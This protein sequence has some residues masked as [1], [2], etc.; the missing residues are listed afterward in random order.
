MVGDL[1]DIVQLGVSSGLCQSLIVGIIRICGTNV[2]VG[3][4]HASA[5]VRVVIVR[6]LVVGGTGGQYTGFNNVIRRGQLGSVD[7]CGVFLAVNGHGN[8]F[9]VKRSL[10]VHDCKGKSFKFGFARVKL[11]YYVKIA[12]Q[13]VFVLKS[14]CVVGKL[15]IGACC[16]GAESRCGFALNI[17][18]I[19][20]NTNSFC[21]I[22][23]VVKHVDHATAGR[24]RGCIAVIHGQAF[25][26]QGKLWIVVGALHDERVVEFQRCTIGVRNN[27]GNANRHAV[28]LLQG[29]HGCQGV[30]KNKLVVARGRFQQKFAVGGVVGGPASAVWHGAV[31][32]LEGGGG[33]QCAVVIRHMEFANNGV[34]T[35]GSTVGDFVGLG[36]F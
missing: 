35:L 22:G 29:L 16:A 30:I 19:G 9:K 27:N 1:N 3:G 21:I 12:C 8:G 25:G 13:C 15:A 36:I 10:A 6:V 34:G 7:D 14:F 18:V 31:S 4:G 5:V 33:S 23:I 32:E 20:N 17:S 28:P 2:A 26:R 11:A 24:I